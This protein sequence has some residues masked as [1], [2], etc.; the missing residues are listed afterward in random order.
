[1]DLQDKNKK[2]TFLRNT[3]ISLISIIGLLTLILLQ[4]CLG[5]NSSPEGD[6]A[7][8]PMI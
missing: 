8:L 7:S 4:S 1:M 2:S 6:K 3:V 5:G